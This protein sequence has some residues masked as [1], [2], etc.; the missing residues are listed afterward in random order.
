MADIAVDTMG[1]VV[2]VASS[3]VN[4]V[5]G[6]SIGGGLV[7]IGIF[8][9]ESRASSIVLSDVVPRSVEKVERLREEERVAVAVAARRVTD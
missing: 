3:A 5:V 4:S 7:I 6:I 8:N 1:P 9:W 2:V